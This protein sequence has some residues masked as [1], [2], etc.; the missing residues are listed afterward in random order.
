MNQLGAALA[1]QK[2]YTEAEPLIV[3]GYKGMKSH[4]TSMP[5]WATH[6]LHEAGERVVRMYEAWDKPGMAAQWK[7]RLG[8]VGPPDLPADLIPKS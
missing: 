2:R 1:G 3:A 5:S 7:I 6:R 4:E 8:L